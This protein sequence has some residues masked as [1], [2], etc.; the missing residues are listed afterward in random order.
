[1]DHIAARERVRI[2]LDRG[3]AP[4]LSNNEID[5]FLQM[6]ANEFIRERVDKAGATQRLRDDLGHYLR[7]RVYIPRALHDTLMNPGTNGTYSL[8]DIGGTN[9]NDGVVH[10]FE[11]YNPVQ[12]GNPGGY[13]SSVGCNLGYIHDNMVGYIL[14]IR[15]LWFSN[16]EDIRQAHLTDPSAEV[17]PNFTEFHNGYPVKILNLDDAHAIQ[18]DPFHQ[19]TVESPAAV[20]VG[21]I[22]YIMPDE[23]SGTS[24][25]DSQITGCW[26]V[27]FEFILNNTSPD[28]AFQWF[29]NHS[30]EEVCQIAARKIMASTADERYNAQQNEIKQSELR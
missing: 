20:R 9:A 6:A 11:N 25:D 24:V 5:A 14:G 1:M 13:W 28:V 4:W 8:L 18:R 21:N 27:A 23:I 26:G 19:P 3:D 7:S 30:R 29:P 2:I 12:F 16:P 10:P 17:N 15:T 22:Y